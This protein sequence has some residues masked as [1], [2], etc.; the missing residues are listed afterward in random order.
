MSTDPAPD[1]V[2]LRDLIVRLRAPDGCP[3]DQKQ[4]LVD[5]RAYV[6]EEAHEVAAALDLHAAGED[7]GLAAELGDLL[8][9][10]VFVTVLAEEAGEFDLAAVIDGIH[11]KMVERH[12]HVFGDEVLAD[13]EEVKK[14]WEARKVEARNKD[15]Q[16]VVEGSLLDGVAASL[17]AL[18]AAYRMTQKAAG[19]GFD[20]PDVDGVLAKVREELAEFEAELDERGAPRDLELARGELGDLLFTVANLGRR[21]GIDPEAALAGT[22]LKFRRRFAG[23]EAGL[24]ERGKSLV[25]A[26]LDEMDALWNTVKGREHR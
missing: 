16:G 19:V 24:A 4:T 7:G 18:T 20:W 11:A 26:D 3:W 21:L 1:I 23:V 25:E 10:V 6:L 22:N 13:V 12:P 5:L 9:Q 2:K 15:G 17:P 14:A 8:F